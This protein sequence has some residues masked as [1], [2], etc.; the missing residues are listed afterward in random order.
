MCMFVHAQSLSHVRLFVTPRTIACQ[1]PLFMGV[2]RQEYWSGLPFPPPGDLADPGSKP[3]SPAWQAD[4]S[5]LSPQGSPQLLLLR[6]NNIRN[7]S[8]VYCLSKTIVFCLKRGKTWTTWKLCTER[9]SWSLADI[10]ELAQF[11]WQQITAPRAQ[12]KIMFQ[13]FQNINGTEIIKIAQDGSLW[14]K[15]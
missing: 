12:L 5:P 7:K 14:R 4:S 10:L 8:Y 2:L 3:E 1:A 13:V 15:L 11:N 9:T 6:L